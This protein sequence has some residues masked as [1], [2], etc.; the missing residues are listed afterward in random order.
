MRNL[1]N[2]IRFLAVLFFI[3]ILLL[4][5]SGCK[6][7]SAFETS[8]EEQSDTINE[9]EPQSE[10]TDEQEETIEDTV[11]DRENNMEEIKSELFLILNSFFQ[12]VKEGNH[13]KE[14][15]FFDSYT[16]G[17][18][19]SEEEYRNGTKS[20]IFYIIQESHSSWKNTEAESLI[21][22][23]NRAILTITGDRNAEE[24]ES[25]DEKIGF[26]FINEEGNWKI[27]FYYPPI[28][29]IMPVS[30]EP[31]IVINSSEITYLLISA[32]IKSFFAIRDIRLLLNNTE[33]NPGII[34]EDKY[35]REISVEIPTGNLI[36][37][38]NKTIC[39]AADVIERETD[40]N[41]SF[42][43]R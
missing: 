4:S 12:A 17:M 38:L 18:V 21:L 8:N 25:I 7:T 41:W 2:I 26:K 20:D 22:E 29:A 1:T 11:T 16:R 15:E 28:I 33:L 40:Y 23:G 32:E 10:I 3:F 43:V 5:F 30:P 35:E 37:G 39:Y 34:G 36:I 19:G 27:D 31:D 42:T 6:K 13:D 14:Y 24:I 9:E